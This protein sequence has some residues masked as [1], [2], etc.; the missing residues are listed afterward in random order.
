MNAIYGSISRKVLNDVFRSA[1][2]TTTIYSSDLNTKPAK[3]GLLSLNIRYSGDAYTLLL[4]Q[5]HFVCIDWMAS[6]FCLSKKMCRRFAIAFDNTSNEWDRKKCSC[7][8]VWFV[9]VPYRAVWMCRLWL[10]KCV[11]ASWWLI[12]EIKSI[13][14]QFYWIKSLNRNEGCLLDRRCFY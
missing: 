12:F 4:K 1:S 13:K 5:I 10:I 9:R 14:T 7:M 6:T 3:N 2:A 11:A 8:R